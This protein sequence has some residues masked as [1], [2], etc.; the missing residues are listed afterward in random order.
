[1]KMHVV[2]FESRIPYPEN[3]SYMIAV[4]Q[5]RTSNDPDCTY[6]MYSESELPPYWAK[7]EV[8]LKKLREVPLGDVVLWL[9]TDAVVDDTTG[10]RKLLAS[11]TFTKSNEGEP[12][13][14]AVPFNAGVWGVKHNEMGISIMEYWLSLYDSSVWHHVEPDEL[15]ASDLRGHMSTKDWE[16]DG[17]WAQGDFEQ[18]SFRDKVL[19]KFEEHITDVPWQVL[20]Y[21]DPDTPEG[22]LAHHF[23]CWKHSKW[24]KRCM[25]GYFD[26]VTDDQ[27]R[28]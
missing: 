17:D 16:C 15:S 8:A 27:P 25:W 1:M 9:D 23:A 26:S 2:Q 24:R 20:Q 28:T 11:G 4:N 14:D 21:S 3:N 22:T 6:T 19:P 18:G 5:A 7:V 12:W 13:P 10:M